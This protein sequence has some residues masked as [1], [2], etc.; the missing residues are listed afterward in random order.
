MEFIYSSLTDESGEEIEHALEG[1]GYGK[2]KL[3]I[4]EVIADALEPIQENFYELNQPENEKFINQIFRDG[5]KKA[6]T[7]AERKLNRVFDVIGFYKK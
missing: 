7:I 2:F 4:A 3:A 6:S 1:Q 5:A